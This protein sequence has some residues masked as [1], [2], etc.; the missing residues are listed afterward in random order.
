MSPNTITKL[1]D[2]IFQFIPNAKLSGK[3]AIFHIDP[4]FEYCDQIEVLINEDEDPWMYRHIKE[5]ADYLFERDWLKMNR[6]RE[7][8]NE[9]IIINELWI[10]MDGHRCIISID[11]KSYEQSFF[12]ANNVQI[13]RNGRMTPRYCDRGITP[14]EYIY[15]SKQDIRDRRL[16]LAR[17]ITNIPT[18][19]EKKYSFQK[20][21]TLGGD[22]VNNG[23]KID[24]N[25][26][27]QLLRMKMITTDSNDICVICQESIN[28]LRSVILNCNHFY[29]VNCL[30]N[31]LLGVGT[32]TSQC[33]IC[34]KEII[35]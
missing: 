20:L 30:R 33:S 2:M 18:S 17:P 24:P 35:E 27:R 21:I 7:F 10:E 34:R 26:Q 13:D 4:T 6:P 3:Y 8:Y 29:H 25:I 5:L 22:L 19:Y 31:Q 15:F 28:G 1:K 23:W 9:H 16:S 11:C 12:H 14:D 32:T